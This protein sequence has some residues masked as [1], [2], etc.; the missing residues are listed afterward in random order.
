MAHYA[1]LNDQ[2]VVVQVITGRD[3]TDLPDGIDDWENYYGAFHG[4]TCRR[5]SYNTR[6][7][8][9]IDGGTP[10]RG[11]YAGVGYTYDPDRDAF[12]A[13]E[14]PDAIGFDEE[15]LT[16]ILPEPEPEA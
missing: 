12:I 3:E 14:P 9:H 10:F 13:P 8:Q 4:L 2:N 1:L 5:T 11:N 6:G 7:N 15:T 16:W